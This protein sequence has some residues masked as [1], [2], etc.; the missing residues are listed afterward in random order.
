VEEGRHSFWCHV[1][2]TVTSCLHPSAIAPKVCLKAT[3]FGDLIVTNT[4]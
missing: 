4:D 1:E 2:V 3:D